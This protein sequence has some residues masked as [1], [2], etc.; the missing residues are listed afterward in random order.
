M[1]VAILSGVLAS[2]DS[3]TGLHHSAKWEVHTP[4]TSTP[5][6]QPDDYLPSRFLACVSRS[7]TANRLK[8]TFS[9]LSPLGQK[10]EILSG[11]NTRAVQEADLILLWRVHA[12]LC[13]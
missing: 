1:G 5:V 11:Q 7:E 4:G 12:C 9:D 2:L 6:G 8:K 13:R 10:V 3:L